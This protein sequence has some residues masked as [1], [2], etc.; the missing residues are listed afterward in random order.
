MYLFFFSFSANEIQFQPIKSENI[1]TKRHF[2]IDCMDQSARFQSQ[3]M[4]STRIGVQPTIPVRIN[5]EG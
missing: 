5:W 3:I 1:W 2:E 4:Q